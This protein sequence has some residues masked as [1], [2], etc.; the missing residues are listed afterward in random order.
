MMC[1][2]QVVLLNS[3]RHVGPHMA[4]ES[5]TL[6]FVGLQIERRDQHWWLTAAA[7][8]ALAVAP[9]WRLWLCRRST[10]ICDTCRTANRDGLA[11]PDLVGPDVWRAGRSGVGAASGADATDP[12]RPVEG[13][14]SRV[15]DGE[16]LTSMAGGHCALDGVF[17]SHELR[18][19]LVRPP[20][21][22][23][24]DILSRRRKDQR[25]AAATN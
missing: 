15:G 21:R 23:L 11:T 20:G 3:N 9:G 16:L 13:Y 17:A 2:L 18:H 12:F 1:R 8:F 4:F 5:Q 7:A 25:A 6:L 24:I 22:F 19:L 10:C 14:P